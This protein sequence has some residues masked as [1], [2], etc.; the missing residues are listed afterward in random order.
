MALQVR[1]SPD[2]RP[3]EDL[4]HIA[5]ARLVGRRPA[6][7]RDGD[8]PGSGVAARG[9]TVLCGLAPAARAGAGSSR[10]RVR[11]PHQAPARGWLAGL[12][13]PAAARGEPVP[14]AARPQPR[15]L[16][17]VG[18]CWRPRGAVPSHS[19]PRRRPRSATSLGPSGFL[20]PEGRESNVSR[21]AS[22]FQALTQSPSRASDPRPEGLAESARARAEFPHH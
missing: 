19:L 2:P 12:H 16:A 20:E 6:C 13:Q 3:P 1:A 4:L 14:A 9:S 15:E 5:P 22:F 11:A 21:R 8:G 7:G 10:T 17:S 18:P